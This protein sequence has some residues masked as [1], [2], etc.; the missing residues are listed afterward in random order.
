MKYAGA[1]LLAHLLTW[2]R[3]PQAQRDSTMG[4]AFAAMLL[5]AAGFG[6]ILALFGIVWLIGRLLGG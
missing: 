3:V 6:A 4:V 1:S 2:S 5:F